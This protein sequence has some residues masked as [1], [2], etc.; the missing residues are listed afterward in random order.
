ML[1]LLAITC[2]IRIG[3]STSIYLTYNW[4]PLDF[5]C[6]NYKSII[7]RKHIL[8]WRIY[9]KYNDQYYHLKKKT[10]HDNP[11]PFKGHDK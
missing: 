11:N 3:T 10:K 2:I 7:E 5:F 1:M 6:P 8:Y 9:N 4:M